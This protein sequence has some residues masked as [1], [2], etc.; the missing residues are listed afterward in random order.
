MMGELHFLRPWWWLALLAL[1]A[2]W[3]ALRRG[4]EQLRAWTRVVDAHLL[5]HLVTG[6]EP[7]RRAPLVLAIAGWVIAVAALAGPAWERLPV[8]VQ[9][10]QAAT[11]V[12]F[13]LAPTML[14]ADLKP[15]RL[16]RARYKV[17]D[18]LARLRDGQT[19]L[20][21]YAGDAF[22]V[23]PLTDDGKTVE[24]LLDGL[25]PTVMPVGGNAT[26]VAINT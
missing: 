22:V 14:A 18:L 13:E 1:P 3:F 6:A 5:P 9:R 7:A 20:I 23:A 4:D 15:D 25:D 19:A 10:N 17:R 11:V 16:T 26:A 12:A 2:L 24:N 8:P 21:G